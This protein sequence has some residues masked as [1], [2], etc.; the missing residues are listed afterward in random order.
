MIGMVKTDLLTYA[1]R[2]DDDRR[3]KYLKHIISS[4][5]ASRVNGALQIAS[6]LLGIDAASLDA[7]G[8]LMNLQNGTI[9]LLTGE[10]QRHKRED[11]L[12]KIA[13]VSFDDAARAPTWEKFIGRIFQ[14]ANGHTQADVV[15]YIQKAL[16]YSMTAEVSEQCLFLLNGNGRNGKTTLLDAVKFVLGDYAM[17]AQQS[18]LLQLGNGNAFK[19]NSEDEAS[20]F[21]VRFASCSE[22]DEGQ[23]L[24]ESKVK[25]LVGG[26]QITAMRKYEH[27][28]SFYPTHKIWL[29]CN[30]LPK[31]R[32]ADDGIWRRIKRIPFIV[33]IPLAERDPKLGDKL[34]AEGSGILR[35]ILDGL[36]R[37]RAEGLQEPKAISDAV[38]A[39]RTD[40]DVFGMFLR[41]CVENND[42]ETVLA[43]TLYARYKGWC[44]QEGL[45]HPLT[46]IE[47]GKR[48]R[49]RGYQEGRKST[50]RFWRGMSLKD[51]A[52][53]DDP[54]YG[55]GVDDDRF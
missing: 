43:S 38:N 19:T 31:I 42:A 18:L 52:T 36:L 12:T 34:R 48:M 1:Q 16:G 40:S 10:L 7:N 35:W 24:D 46:Q 28:V 14:D 17:T 15:A 4:Q 11:L 54:V 41:D 45:D 33:Q 5:S 26:G 8:D 13:P 27:P 51:D 32:G 6:S 22:T 50:A 2:L 21:G 47:F 30:H 3:T 9:N 55:N 37:W 49:E 25:R 53:V 23:R 20:L 29:D 44:G 39:F